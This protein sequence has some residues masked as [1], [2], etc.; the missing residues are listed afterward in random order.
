[1]APAVGKVQPWILMPERRR[2]LGV[3][4]GIDV[5]APSS[6]AKGR[7]SG[8]SEKERRGRQRQPVWRGG[9]E[10]CRPSGR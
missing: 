9:E 3:A 7:R 1:V 2:E 10:R 5:V 8:R 4:P 6:G